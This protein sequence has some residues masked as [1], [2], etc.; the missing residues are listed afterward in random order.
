MVAC[1]SHSILSN[2]FNDQLAYNL[3]A[4]NLWPT[5]T[6]F[7]YESSQAQG[8]P[9]TYVSVFAARQELSPEACQKI[10]KPALLNVNLQDAFEMPKVLSK[11]FL[12]EWSRHCISALTCQ[13]AARIAM[14]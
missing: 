9:G 10:A 12:K 5:M 11:V 1:N 2:Q 4:C 8:T 3:A 14:P 7:G 13:I 6:A